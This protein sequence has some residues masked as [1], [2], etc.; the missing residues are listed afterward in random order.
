MHIE[1]TIHYIFDLLN[2]CRW[3]E[4]QEAIPYMEIYF[5]IKAWNT[6]MCLDHYAR[7][8]YTNRNPYSTVSIRSG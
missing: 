6:H 1:V 8:A 3:T 4:V 2:Q 7:W 5:D